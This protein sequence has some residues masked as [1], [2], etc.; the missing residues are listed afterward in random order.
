MYM[1]CTY[2]CIYV[3]TRICTIR[4]YVCMCSAGH[5]KGL[6]TAVDP[7]AVNTPSAQIM[8][9]KYH[10]PLNTENTDRVSWG[11]G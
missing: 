10:F 9:L 6:G 4:P 8:V 5:R 11:D 1:V 3:C 7:A 2:A